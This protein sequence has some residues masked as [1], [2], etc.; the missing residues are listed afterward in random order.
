VGGCGGVSGWVSVCFSDGTFAASAK[1]SSASSA[2]VA[3]LCTAI[4][5]LPNSAAGSLSAARASR[6]SSSF[7]GGSGTEVYGD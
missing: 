7:I 3:E 5:T 1:L 6:V 2:G 4:G